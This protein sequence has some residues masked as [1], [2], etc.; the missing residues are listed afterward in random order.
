MKPLLM[1]VLPLLAG[2]AFCVVETEQFQIQSVEREGRTAAFSTQQEQRECCN[3]N[4]NQC[5]CIAT[6][7]IPGIP[8]QL[9]QKGDKGE[10]GDIGRPGRRGPKGE[11]GDPGQKGEPGGGPPGPAGFSDSPK[12]IA[13]FAMAPEPQGPLSQ[14]NATAFKDVRLNAGKGYSDQ[15]FKFIAPIGGIYAFFVTLRT[16]VTGAGLTAFI[17]H[18]SYHAVALYAGN[19]DGGS[20]C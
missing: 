5:C 14:H 9:G 7:G 17:M 12:R 11:N 16:Q 6:A 10:I 19:Q 4:G 1:F 2:I 13:F 15:S 20:V 3:Q 8:G 18:G